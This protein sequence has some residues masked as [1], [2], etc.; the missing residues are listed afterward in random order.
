MRRW[1][2]FL[3]LFLAATAASAGDTLRLP[4]SGGITVA[5]DGTVQSHVLAKGLP[6]AV[7]SLVSGAIGKWEFE[8]VVRNGVPSYTRCLI[9]MTLLATEVSGGYQLRVEDVR[10]SGYR[11]PASRESPEYPRGALRMGIEALVLV[12]QR[13]DADGKV[14]DT[15]PVQT[16]L[17]NVYG[18]QSDAERWRRDLEEAAVEAAK[19]WRYQKAEPE[20]GDPLETTIVVPVAFR[21]ARPSE[22]V[23]P[24]QWHRDELRGPRHAIPWL[25]PDQQQ[26]VVD[27]LADGQVVTLDSPVA[28]KTPVRGAAL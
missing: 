21:I 26:F 11:Q 9:Q 4:V 8:P 28:L 2:W 16:T 10:F 22:P 12:A 24:M 18:E 17:T 20:H 13:I 1:T 14:L 6:P 7:E 23:A 5:P 25:R 3:A 27:G 15:A 19:Q